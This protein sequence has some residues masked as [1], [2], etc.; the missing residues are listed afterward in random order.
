MVLTQFSNINT[1]LEDA[2]DDNIQEKWLNKEMEN[3]KEKLDI[4][5]HI[6]VIIYSKKI[7]KK[8]EF[9]KREKRKNYLR[10]NYY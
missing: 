2:I 7:S 6:Q 10:K 9:E 3:Q 5:G 8:R 1:C 4:R